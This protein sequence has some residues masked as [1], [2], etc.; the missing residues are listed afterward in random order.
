MPWQQILSVT[1][2]YC[3]TTQAIATVL[4]VCDFSLCNV[5]SSNKVSMIAKNIQQVAKCHS[6]PLICSEIFTCFIDQS[7]RYATGRSD[8]EK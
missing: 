8:G 3:T 6:R 4:A 1:E 5:I 7:K 2:H